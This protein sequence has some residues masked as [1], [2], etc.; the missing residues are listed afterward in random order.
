MSKV[1]VAFLV[2]LLASIGS[3]PTA[4]QSEKLFGFVAINDED[5]ASLEHTGIVSNS[6]AIGAEDWQQIPLWNAEAIKKRPLVLLDQ[7]L[8]L[9]DP[10]NSSSPC[11]PAWRL[12]ANWQTR[13]NIWVRQA[14][15]YLTNNAIAGLV[16]IEEAN[17]NCI[18][19]E[20]LDPVVSY[21]R[22][23][24]PEG[25]PIGIGEGA[26]N[27]SLPL[28][29]IL[30][31]SID[32]VALFNYDVLDPLETSLQIPLETIKSQLRPGE[33]YYLVARAFLYF[34][35]HGKKPARLGDAMAAYARFCVDE[36]LCAGLLGFL[37]HGQPYSLLG[38]D[39]MPTAW[40]GDAEASRI[41]L[42]NP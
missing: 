34:G 40:R 25:I 28:L 7:L 6:G 16:P 9:P 11:R 20:V 3:A 31:E 1:G 36:P 21:V 32:F 24:V 10:S 18:G 42:L 15:K 4:A 30:P 38:T 27:G 12:R 29:A 41:L 22:S 33:T 39:Q 26:G 19:A 37:F 5:F 2:V 13:I 14:R 35:E 17:N 8:F 23:R